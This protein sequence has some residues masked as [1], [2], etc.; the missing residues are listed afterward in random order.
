MSVR[1]YGDVQTT[2]P[3]TPRLQARLQRAIANGIANPTRT[4]PTLRRAVL[5]ASAELRRQGYE[6]EQIVP[7]F[8][9]FVEDV[10]RTCALD[11]R[12]VVSGQ[13]RW[14]DVR[15]R[16]IEWAMVPVAPGSKPVSLNPPL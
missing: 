9:R 2:A 15:D 1:R 16:V 11:A 7:L 14:I 12:S 5:V 3:F 4:L 8:A 10:V 13:P 6:D